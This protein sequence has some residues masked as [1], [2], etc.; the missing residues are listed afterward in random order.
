MTIAISADVKIK[1]YENIEESIEDMLSNLSKQ[2]ILNL[3][4]YSSYS[5]WDEYV[6][7]DGEVINTSDEVRYLI[8]SDNSDFQWYVIKN[9][10]TDQSL[11]DAFANAFLDNTTL[12]EEDADFVDVEDSIMKLYDYADV[13]DVLRNEN[14]DDMIEEIDN[15]INEG[16]EE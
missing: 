16:E 13:Y 8:D 15:L 10:T 5:N 1:V 11:M 4:R 6:C 12:D 7:Y 14:W 3:G 9:E 2:E